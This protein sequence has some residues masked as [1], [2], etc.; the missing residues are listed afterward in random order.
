MNDN[1]AK[2]RV[3]KNA[4]WIVGCKVI[5]SLLTLC[6]GMM[7]AR[8]LGPSNY[9]L[10]SYAASVVAFFVPIMQLGFS[11]TLVNEIIV[12]PEKEGVLV[13]TALSFNI[14]SAIICVIG[15]NVF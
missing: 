13:G 1:F 7:T 15:V 8:Y 14:I 6:I 3:M 11:A 4:T 12:H 5:Q 10:I 9:G 2:S